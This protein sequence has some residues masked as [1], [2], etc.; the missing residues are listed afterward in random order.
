M[1]F[2]RFAAYFFAISAGSTV[3]FAPTLR[4][5]P[6]PPVRD[7]EVVLT[8]ADAGLDVLPPDTVCAFQTMW[9]R[10][11]HRPVSRA[12]QARAARAARAK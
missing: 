4:G 3:L 10:H 5:Q 12:A 9:D 6:A 1:S 11:H 2:R 7:A 8:P